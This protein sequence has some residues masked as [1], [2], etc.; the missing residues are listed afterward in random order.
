[1]MGDMRV[2]KEAAILHHSWVVL[3]FTIRDCLN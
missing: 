3:F 1:M 2:Y